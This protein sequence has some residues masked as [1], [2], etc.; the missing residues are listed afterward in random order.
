MALCEKK[1]QCHS[2]VKSVDLGLN[3]ATCNIR[4]LKL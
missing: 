3:T 1:N 2:R 4:S